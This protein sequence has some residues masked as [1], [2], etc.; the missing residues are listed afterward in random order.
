VLPKFHKVGE[1]PESFLK[2]TVKQSCYFYS[3]S[4]HLSILLELPA[5]LNCG[6]GV[7]S[8]RKN[9]AH[10]ERSGE[11]SHIQEQ[12]LMAGSNCQAGRE[13]MAQH[14]LWARRGFCGRGRLRKLVHAGYSLVGV[15]LS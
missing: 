11:K 5:P 3:H 9:T 4:P 14:R 13:N 15:G 10:K 7:L 12:S 8:V 1:E 2:M 6:L